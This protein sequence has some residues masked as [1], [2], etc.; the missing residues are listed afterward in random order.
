MINLKEQYIKWDNYPN[1]KKNFKCELRNTGHWEKDIP[2][3]WLVLFQPSGE[4]NAFGQSK[5]APTYADLKNLLSCMMECER[6]ND[7]FGYSYNCNESFRPLEK[8]KKLKAIQSMLSEIDVNWD[9]LDSELSILKFEEV[10]MDKLE[11]MFKHQADLQKRL[12]VPNRVQD[13][14]SKQQYI[15]QMI[16]ALHEEATEIMRETPYKNPELVPFG[17]KKGQVGDNEKFKDEIAD[18]MHF[19]LNLA[20]VSGMDAKE[21]HE[22]YLGKNKENFDRQERGY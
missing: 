21:L 16:L 18:I 13:P 14:K 4:L 11:D 19:V 8:K 7:M 22:R 10:K 6:R 9:K 2:G 5:T 1:D 15:N 3:K 20:L 17:W 12:D